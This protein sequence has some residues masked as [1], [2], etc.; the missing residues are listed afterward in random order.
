M[1]SPE[2]E[3][4]AFAF[5]GRQ[6][7]SLHNTRRIGVAPVSDVGSSAF[8]N[9]FPRTTQGQKRSWFL[10]DGDRRDAYPT[11]LATCAR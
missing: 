10:E 11:R 3:N 4:A 6:S 1:P 8:G 5:G 9:E 7:F 2:I